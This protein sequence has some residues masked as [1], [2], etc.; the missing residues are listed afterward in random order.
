M[1]FGQSVERVIEDEPRP[2]Q[3]YRKTA[4]ETHSGLPVPRYVSLKFSKVNGRQGP[5]LQHNVLWQYRRRGLP[6]IVVAETDNWRKVRDNTGEESWVRRVALSGTRTALTKREVEIRTRPG[7]GTRIKAVA[8]GNVLL[9]L[10]ECD[11]Q[12]WCK[13]KSHDG[14]KGYVRRADLWGAGKL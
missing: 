11:A 9:Y 1:A 10:G 6:L 2:H 14:H 7:D 4:A 8:Q 3:F 5:T 13:V 12:D